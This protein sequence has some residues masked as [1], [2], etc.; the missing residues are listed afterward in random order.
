MEP[1][2]FT[3]WRLPVQ[4]TIRKLDGDNYAQWERV[5]KM[6]LIGY[7]RQRHL[8]ENAPNHN[9]PMHDKWVQDDAHIISLMWNSMEN[10]IANL[11][12]HVETFNTLW[13]HLHHLFGSNL[14]RMYD[15]SREFF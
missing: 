12:S 4:L 9:D 7:G 14:I 6:A 13:Y 2:I 3:S 1:K 11:C 10:K 5:V 15:A 8:Y